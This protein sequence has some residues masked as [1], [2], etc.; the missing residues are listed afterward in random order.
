MMA[1]V[2]IILL[3]GIVTKNSILL[4]DYTIT[5]RKRGMGRE[6]ALLKA[7]PV[8]LRPILMTSAAMIMGML[9]AALGI[10]EG[11]EWRRSMGISVIGG[12]ITSTLLTLL[13]V[14]VTY[15]VVDKFGEFLKRN[16]KI[17]G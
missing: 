9:P 6:E 11:A 13:V 15:V 1:M 17:G 3:M 16:I 2:G 7:G 5:L 10:G 12:L 4:I 14:P 8:R